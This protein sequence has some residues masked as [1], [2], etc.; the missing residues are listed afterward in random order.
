MKTKDYTRML[1]GA[2]SERGETIKICPICGKRGAYVPPREIIKNGKRSGKF[3]S[4]EYIHIADIYDGSEGGMPMRV[5]RKTCHMP[6]V[7]D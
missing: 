7:E 4:A 1:K 2:K 3:V 6:A 5:T